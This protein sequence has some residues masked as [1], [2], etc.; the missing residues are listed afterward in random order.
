MNQTSRGLPTKGRGS[1]RQPGTLIRD[2]HQLLGEPAMLLIVPQDYVCSQAP[3]E[4]RPNL[5]IRLRIAKTHVDFDQIPLESTP[6]FGSW[7]RM[8]VLHDLHS[9]AIPGSFT[10]IFGEA[11]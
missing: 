8:P 6:G 2:S 10:R 9:A 5:H 1:F 7:R 3:L 4:D 11:P